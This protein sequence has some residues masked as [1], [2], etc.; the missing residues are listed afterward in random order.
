MS[1]NRLGWLLEEVK[2]VQETKLLGVAKQCNRQYFC[3]LGAICCPNNSIK[4]PNDD[5]VPDWEPSYWRYGEPCC[6]VYLMQARCPSR[7]L[8]NNTEALDDHAVSRQRRLSG[9]ELHRDVHMCML[10]WL[11]LNYRQTTLHKTVTT[12]NSR[13]GR[14]YVYCDL[15]DRH[16]ALLNIPTVGTYI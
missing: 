15:L 3:G 13:P 6:C 7:H 11:W 12:G 9:Y 14:Y 16:E 4:A 1:F 10:R 8:T 2:P 5:S